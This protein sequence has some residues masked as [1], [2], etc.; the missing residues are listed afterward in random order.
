MDDHDAYLALARKAC[1]VCELLDGNPEYPHHIAYRDETAVVFA[2]RFP[3]VRGH[4]LVAPVRHL[5]HAVDDFPLDDYLAL[6]RVIHVAGTALTRII[7]TERLYVLSF[8]SQQA[9]R[10]VHWHLAPLPPG[11][12]YERQQA[13]LFT[14][15]AGHLRVPDHEL[16]ALAARVGQAF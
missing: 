6:H 12:P 10:H 3:S 2:S 9:N 16:A 7:P 14:P 1:F 8:G 11:L 13:A 5:E 4:L 15:A